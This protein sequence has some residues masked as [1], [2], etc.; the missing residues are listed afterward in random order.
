M[1]RIMHAPGKSAGNGYTEILPMGMEIDFLHAEQ[2]TV[3]NAPVTSQQA[4]GA[5]SLTDNDDESVH[6]EVDRRDAKSTVRQEHSNGAN[7]FDGQARAHSNL[8]LHRT[9]PRRIKAHRSRRKYYDSFNR[10]LQHD[11]YAPRYSVYHDPGDSH[12]RACHPDRGYREPS[13]ETLR[14]RAETRFVSAMADLDVK[15]EPR[16]DRRDGD[17]YRGGGNNKRRRDGKL[18]IR[19]CED[20]RD[21]NTG[22]ADDND[23]YARD[24]GRGPQRRRNDDAPPRRRYEEPPFPKLRRLLLNIASST[25]LPQD[26]AI[27]IAKYFGEHFDDERL[28]S[29][30]FDVWVQL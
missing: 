19:C 25:K 6:M 3:M 14:N 8:D 1:S 23:N 17:R 30:F 24:R 28:R 27:E 2:L 4:I 20:I 13:Q 22:F 26:E 11:C 29:D 12:G 5:V 10:Y 7:H 9:A 15:E 18:V 21:T 16:E